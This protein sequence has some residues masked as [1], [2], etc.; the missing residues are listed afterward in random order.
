MKKN[1]IENKNE[2]SGNTPK[3]KKQVFVSYSHADMNIAQSVIRA[4][5]RRGF[6]IWFDDE[7]KG[8]PPG[9]SW[10]SYIDK[11]LAGAGKI[12]FFM[13]R[14]S[15]KRPQVIRELKMMLEQKKEIIT[16]MLEEVPFSRIE[17]EELRSYFNQI[18][19][20]KLRSYGGLNGRFI[21][22][23]MKLIGKDFCENWQEPKE[24]ETPVL[25]RMEE[26]EK[27]YV[28]EDGYPVLERQLVDGEEYCF[29]KLTP[30]DISPMMVFPA[31]MD[32]QWFPDYMYEQRGFAGKNKLEKEIAWNRQL[33]Q[34][35]EI[36]LSLLHAP[37]VLLNRAFLLN[38]PFIYD[39]YYKGSPRYT[40]TEN[41]AFSAL[42]KQGA[43]CLYLMTEEHPLEIPKFQVIP[44]VAE[45]WKAFGK[46]AGVHCLKL[47]WDKETN[48]AECRRR[49]FVPFYEFCV[50]LCDEPYRVD[51][52]MNELGIPKEK[53]NLFKKKLIQVRDHAMKE[54]YK[55]GQ[56]FN[57]TRSQFYRAFVVKKGSNIPEGIFDKRKPFST[58]LKRIADLKYNCNLADACQCIYREPKHSLKRSALAEIQAGNAMYRQELKIEDLSY[59]ISEFHV[60]LPGEPIKIPLTKH[61][62]FKLILNTRTKSAYWKEYM[63]NVERMSRRANQWM[64][65]FNAMGT[66]M[67][68]FKGFA[69]ELEQQLPKDSCM[70]C[71]DAISIIYQ[72]DNQ[73]I[74]TVYNESEKQRYF[75]VDGSK[76]KAGLAPVSIYFCFG[77]MLHNELDDTICSEILFYQ[78]R[79][80]INGNVFSEKILETLREERFEEVI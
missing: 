45:A 9:E 16:I 27:S 65:D 4:L 35:N 55:A 63:E 37:Q 62:N 47:D 12:L 11:Q 56:G 6:D 42:V 71:E 74:T 70:E 76:V 3:A 31:A 1:K 41:E 10:L 48:L 40:D 30:G 69:A 60:N 53:E 77:D 61:L 15:I 57:F 20:M 51:S 29:Y 26:T 52:L 8:I 73:R 66:C 78:G 80:D 7:G 32:D 13:S 49:L 5:K 54:G 24:D 2:N 25:E 75:H 33:L 72:I 58:E 50:T 38:A 59:A 64:V 23:L 68:Y 39:C 34:R 44:E 18:Q 36:M 21:N 19:V 17:D 43:F 79:T 28:Y 22:A 14:D 67:E 46:Q